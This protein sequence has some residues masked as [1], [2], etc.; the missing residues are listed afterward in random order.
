MVIKGQEIPLGR[1]DGI[2]NT[3]TK[4]KRKDRTEE[5]EKGR[6]TDKSRAHNRK[7]KAMEGSRAQ[8]LPCEYYIKKI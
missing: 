5:E 6:A 7:L 8:M 2:F 3:N 4:K 1:S